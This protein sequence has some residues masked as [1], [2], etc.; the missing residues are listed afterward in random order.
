MSTKTRTLRYLRLLSRMD[1]AML[2]LILLLLLTGLLFS[3]GVGREVGGDF[4]G[5][6]KGQLALAVLGLLGYGVLTVLDY[7]KLG[8]WSWV[9][10]GISI[11]VLIIVLTPLGIMRNGARSWLAVPGFGRPMQPSELAKPAVLLFIAWL[12]SR[13]IFHQS[14]WLHCTIPCLAAMA[15]PVLLIGIQPDFGTALVYIPFT[16]AIIF[17]EGIRWRWILGGVTL[18]AILIPL[19]YPRLQH[20]QQDRLKVFLEPP[21]ALALA[22]ASAMLP[23]TTVENIE[24]KKADFFRR[25]SDSWNAEQSLLAV[26]SGGFWGKGFMKGTQHVLGFLP[27]NVASSD[28]VFSVIGEE[29]GFVGAAGVV[30]AFMGLLICSFRTAAGACDDL[31]RN[32]ALGVG[33]IFFTHVFINVGMTIRAAPIIGIPLPFISHGGSF[34]LCSM[35]C[36]GL[37]QSVH[38]RRHETSEA[39]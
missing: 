30:C 27:R 16:L 12:A 9:F 38:I 17:V 7:R 26:G 13:P 5:K 35:A 36:C 10:Y 31:G 25:S 21:A 39:E 3:Y 32:L 23:P 29:T 2:T 19:T 1:K 22:A 8:R 6:W 37:V 18:M 33:V 11:A 14:R 15:L 20:Y 28:F 24:K 4:A 34:M